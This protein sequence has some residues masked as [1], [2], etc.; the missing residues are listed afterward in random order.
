MNVL[1]SL[2]G[3]GTVIWG[4]R[5]LAGANADASEWKYVP[6]RRLALFIESVNRSGH[7]LGSFRA[8]R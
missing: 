4:A 5:T 2:P 7:A 6:V 1:R 3:S 8:E